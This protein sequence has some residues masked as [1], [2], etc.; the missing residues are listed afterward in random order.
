MRPIPTA[1]LPFLPTSGPT[2][3][4]HNALF[5]PSAGWFPRAI[6]LTTEAWTL[7]APGRPGPATIVNAVGGYDNNNHKPR[8]QLR[9]LGQH[10]CPDDLGRL[11]R[12][13]R[14]R[15]GP[16]AATTPASVA[17]TPAARTEVPA[18]TSTGSVCPCWPSPPTPSK[19]TFPE[20]A[21][22]PDN[23]A[24]QT[25]SSNTSTTSAASSTSLNIH[26][27]SREFR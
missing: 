5:P 24:V 13:V 11:G 21:A 26:S 2:P 1:I 27:D 3:T 19:A 18:S 12:L 7:A 9:R 20:H 14:P 17:A 25:R 8:D 4:S 23:R 15:P 22:S 10:G 6:G 16:G